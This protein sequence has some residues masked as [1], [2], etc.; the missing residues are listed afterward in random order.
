MKVS[1]F[2][3]FLV[4]IFSAC[5]D[6]KKNPKEGKLIN[7]IYSNEYYN[8]AIT[9]PEKWIIQNKSQSK[10][11][12]KDENVSD[13]ENVIQADSLNETTVQLLS[14]FQN[15]V[16]SVET[17]NPSFILM[18]EK[19]PERPAEM[20]ERVYLM[21]TRKQLEQSAIYTSIDNIVKTKNLGGKIFYSLE[22]R[23]IQNKAEI[24]QIFYAHIFKGYALLIVIS[25]AN[26]EAL[27]ELSKTLSSLKFE[28]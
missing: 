11:T 13:D 21:L 8:V 26:N 15:K 28:E 18:A 17:F 27:D 19:L 1:L 25:Y 2:L 24:N 7:N 20:N 10:E 16:G 3:I 22:A 5:S 12:S 6:L 4:I 9:I 14:V 23:S